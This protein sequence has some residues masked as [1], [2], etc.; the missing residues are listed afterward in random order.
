[1]LHRITLLLFSAFSASSLAL[2]MLCD[3]VN[4]FRIVESNF[5][6]SFSFFICK[7]LSDKY[8]E[9]SH[10]LNYSKCLARLIW[11]PCMRDVVSENVFHE[12]AMIGSIR[13]HFQ[14]RLSLGT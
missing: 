5:S 1:M 12:S 3:T 8:H 13:K 6:Y 10:A 2:I 11:L 9:V 4:S 7:V 14:F